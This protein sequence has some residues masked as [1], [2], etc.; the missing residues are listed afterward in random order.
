MT[1]IFTDDWR[2]RAPAMLHADHSCYGDDCVDGTP[3]DRRWLW[4][5]ESFIALGPQTDLIRQ[6]SADLRQYLNAT[7]EH[8]W[9]TYP[10]DGDIPAHRQCTWCHDVRWLNELGVRQ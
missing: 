2:N 4:R 7:C 8:H 10:D 5:L 9:H 3:T 6:M 1:R